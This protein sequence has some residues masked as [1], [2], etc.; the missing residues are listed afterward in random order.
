MPY[1]TPN[2]TIGLLHNVPLDPTY[3]HTIYFATLAAQRAFFQTKIKYSFDN[4]TFQRTTKG[5]LQIRANVTTIYDC[6]YLIFKNPRT[7]NG[8][9]HEKW[10]YAFITNVEYVNEN[11]S[12][13]S[14]QIDVMQTWFFDYQ[15]EMCFVEREHTISDNLFENTVEENIELGEIIVDGVQHYDMNDMGVCILI[16]RKPAGASA[17]VVPSKCLFG[18]YTPVNIVMFDSP[19]AIS[20]IDN[21]IESY[22][23]DDI[24][25]IYQFPLFMLGDYDV[26]AQDEHRIQPAS[27]PEYPVTAEFNL[28]PHT[29]QLDGY[30]PKNNKLF[31]YPYNYITLS[32][33]SGQTADY[34]WEDWGGSFYTG[35]FFVEGVFSTTPACI[36]Y[37]INY[38]LPY[39]SELPLSP[40]ALYDQG[41]TYTAFPLCAWTGDTFKAWWAQNK[42]TL[43]QGIMNS[44]LASMFNLGK[45]IALLASGANP[46]AGASLVGNSLISSYTTTRNAIAQINAVKSMPNQTH[47]QVQVD[48][49]N[50][51]LRKQRFSAY[52]MC[53]KGYRARI[54]DDYFT[55]YGYA[56]M[57]NKV[58]NRN[59]RPH[60]TY[61]KTIGCTI[62]GSIPANDAKIICDIYN[63]GI[64]FWRNGNEVG[65]YTLDNSPA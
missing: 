22:Q 3:D 45:G 35:H 63:N 31:S 50:I 2:T 64:T 15:L 55:R 32:N 36:C 52:K 46:V 25:C 53:V 34:R 56:I 28:T 14:Y 49:L 29:S 30:T 13:V 43:S 27:I 1:I 57:H 26:I 60:W 47:G 41:L 16:S 12:K 11:V 9:T 4:Q 38:Q 54:I 19:S 23:E 58:P 59:A 17:S 48:S 8:V 51:A 6:N 39:D 61:T 7:I 65:D 18:M 44:E 20:S 10:W 21:Y 42:S 24:V 37:P 40:Q 5:V 62:T 33:N